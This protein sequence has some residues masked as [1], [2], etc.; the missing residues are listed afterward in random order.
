[1]M[2]Q[3]WGGPIG[4]GFAGRRSDLVRR[5]II[6]NTF[7]WPLNNVLRI[8]VFSWIMGGPIGRSLTRWF[9]FVP[10]FF[11][12]RGF[13]LRPKREVLDLYMEPWRDPQ[14]REAAVVGPRQ[15]I[16]AAPFLAEVETGLAKLAGKPALI[17]WGMRD[18]AFDQKERTSFEKAFP[19][20]RTV[21]FDNA[22]HFLQEDVGEDIAVHV[23]EF[24]MKDSVVSQGAS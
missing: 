7:A 15:L 5:L 22:S 13:A 3:D 21:L 8:R 19:Q 1:M 18:F 11:F 9:N 16:A 20:H 10:R 23:R 12:L 24:L 6:G 4:L 17:V 2:V 14:R